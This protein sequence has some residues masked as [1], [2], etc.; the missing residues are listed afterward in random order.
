[1]NTLQKE[2][3]QARLR[4]YVS[5]KGSNTKAANSIDGTSPATISQI[6][7]NNWEQ[8][9]DSMWRS[10][11]AQIGW[12]EDDWQLAKTSDYELLSVLLEDARANARVYGV[13]GREGTGKTES[14]KQF[15]RAHSNIFW[16]RGNEFFT[17]KYF[18]QELHRMMGKDYGTM[19]VPELSRSA[20]RE[21]EKLEHPVVI[22]DEADKLP[23]KVLSFFISLYNELEDR[24][25][26]VLGATS[27][28][29]IKVIAGVNKNK[30]GF[31]E[32]YSRL[33]KTF[34]ELDGLS[35]TDI[36]AICVVNGVTDNKVIA[37]I[38]KE[39]QGDIRR[40][41][42]LVQREKLNKA[43]GSN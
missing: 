32:M 9:G 34:V 39:C 1:M 2:Q 24:V 13:V 11:G 33:G 38:S 29:K 27:F 7:N 16:I 25:G 21:L 19:N 37:E 22:F 28:L 31:R 12:T 23:D 26:I 17:P 5:T 40:I 14:F 36:K 6:L 41:K 43:S 18:F 30:R 42:K 15:S 4:Q 8:I 10:I 35:A 3:I 20:V